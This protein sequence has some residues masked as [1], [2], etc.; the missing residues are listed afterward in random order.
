MRER[1]ARL[2]VLTVPRAGLPSQGVAAPQAATTIAS[3]VYLIRYVGE[4]GSQG[5]G[6]LFIG[7]GTISGS[8][9]VG[10]RYAGTYT[11]EGQRLRAAGTLEVQ[12]GARLVT[13]EIMDAAA[14]RLLPIFPSTS[15][16]VSSTQSC[17]PGA[18]SRF[19]SPKFKIPKLRRQLNLTE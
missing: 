1:Q 11:I 8:D 12:A 9:V 6:T 19:H 14:Y 2:A 13:G 10:G 15:P 5:V 7:N 3:A 18:P 16:P 4:G 17:S